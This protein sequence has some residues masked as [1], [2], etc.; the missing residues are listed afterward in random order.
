[1]LKNLQR[2]K[3][4]VFN[5]FEYFKQLSHIDGDIRITVKLGKTT[6]KAFYSI[7]INKKIFTNSIQIKNQRCYSE[8]YST[9][10]YIMRNQIYND[11]L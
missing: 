10:F 1:M 2:I 8:I 7:C 4:C 6:G 5:A 11:T 3:N 9:A